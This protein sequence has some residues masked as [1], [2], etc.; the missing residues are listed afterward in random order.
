MFRK[1]EILSNKIKA[2]SDS[3]LEELFMGII[4]ASDKRQ[5]EFKKSYQNNNKP[6]K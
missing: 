4:A 5:P 1:R 2:L 3:A 6:P